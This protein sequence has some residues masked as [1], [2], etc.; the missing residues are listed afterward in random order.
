MQKVSI[1]TA[2]RKQK[3]DNTASLILDQ[4]EQEAKAYAL[5]KNNI[6]F[7]LL[8]LFLAF[9]VCKSL[10]KEHPAINYGISM[11][12]PGMLLAFLSGYKQ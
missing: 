4:T 7:L 2:K 5:W 9:V 11:L 6:M 12:A 1:P 3:S 8:S 10:L